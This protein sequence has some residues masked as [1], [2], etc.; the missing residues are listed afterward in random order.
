MEIHI[1]GIGGLHI[2]R[3]KNMKA[4]YCPHMQQRVRTCGDWCPMFNTST[5][6]ESAFIKGCHFSYKIPLANFTDARNK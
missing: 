5:T 2:M 1:D 3:N 6:T 4:Q